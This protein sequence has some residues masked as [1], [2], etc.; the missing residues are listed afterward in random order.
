MSDVKSIL[1]NFQPISL[2]AMDEVAL[3]ERVDEKFTVSLKKTL[4]V[5]SKISD[6]YYCLEINGKRLF[7]YQTEYFDNDNKT[8]FKNHQNGKLT[9]TKLDLETI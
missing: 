3:M 1:V 4:E 6:K 7:N 8:L 2:R 9:D 5:L